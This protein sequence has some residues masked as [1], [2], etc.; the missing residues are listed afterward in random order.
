MRRAFSEKGK[1]AYLGNLKINHSLWQGMLD[2]DEQ[3]L[4]LSEMLS[5]DVLALQQA[6]NSGE[7][8]PEQVEK[9]LAQLDALRHHFAGRSRALRSPE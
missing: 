9:L 7:L 3:T 2:Y 4:V 6:H 1:P 5:A 8:P